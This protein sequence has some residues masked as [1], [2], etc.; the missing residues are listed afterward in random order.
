MTAELRLAVERLYEVFSVYPGD[1]NMCVSP[2]KGTPEEMNGLLFSKPLRDLTNNDLSLFSTSLLYTWGMEPDLKHFL[3]RILELTGELDCP[4]FEVE[5]FF[6]KF[7]IA[8]WLTWPTEEREAITHY[9][10]CLW[11]NI[12]EEPV[13]I[14]RD[15]FFLE[16]F[17]PIVKIYPDLPQLLAT[18]EKASSPVAT[19]R[20]T[21]LI[22][23]EF[24]WLFK[25]EMKCFDKQI[26]PVPELSEWLRSDAVLERFTTAFFTHADDEA[27]TENLSFVV[28]TLEYERSKQ[29]P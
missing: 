19:K 6:I 25:G 1:I 13:P 3:P 10:L 27:Y 15:D 28:R 9:L 8:K 7:E 5:V 14:S 20:L 11:K 4:A 26:K 23:Q 22:Y 2:L 21:A 24:S 16:Y 29:Q 12:L 17:I 18:W